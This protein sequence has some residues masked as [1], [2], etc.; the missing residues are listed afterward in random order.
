VKHKEIWD[1]IE[2]C[3]REN[4]ELRRRLEVLEDRFR[5]HE[6]VRR[7]ERGLPSEDIDVKFDFSGNESSYMRGR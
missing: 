5:S 4:K 3:Q 1:A 6:R 7:H 2:A